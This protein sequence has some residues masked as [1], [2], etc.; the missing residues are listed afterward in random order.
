MKKYILLLTTFAFCFSSCDDWLDV[1]SEN[2]Q[3]EEEQFS[4]YKGFKDAL[5]GCYMKMAEE[6]T[7]GQALT[8]THIETLANLWECPDVLEK[9]SP[10]RYQLNSHNY[11]GNDAQTAIE[12]IYAGLFNIIAQA[13]VIIKHTEEENAAISNTYRSIIAGEAYAI[14]AYCQLDV[15]RLFGQLPQGGSQQ[16]ELP[17]SFC[18][19][20][21]EMPAYYNYAEYVKLLKADIEKALSLLKDN[22]PIF[23][24]TFSALNSSSTL[25]E[26]DFYYYRQSRLNYWAVKA[27]QARMYLYIGETSNAATTAMEIINAK[28]ADEKPLM[29]LS[30][31][32]DMPNKYY[33][34]PSECLFCLSKYNLKESANAYLL[35]GENGITAYET[36]YVL[37]ESRLADLYASVSYST[38]SHNR[39]NNWWNRTVKNNSAIISPALKKYWYTD[40]ATN[41]MLKHQ[42]IPMLR[43]SEIYLIAIETATDLTT[44]NSLYAEYM[45]ACAVTNAPTFTSLEEI[46]EEVINEYRR[47]FF[48]EGQM[49]YTY[50]RNFV[51]KMLWNNNEVTEENYIVPL[52]LTEYNPNK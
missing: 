26:D 38:G 17:Y 20:I 21:D 4:E 14:R 12:G 22:D 37:T 10:G 34:L 9:N 29:P 35:G 51:T 50:K 46:K 15:L 6:S 8:M 11:S 45:R 30:G 49:F 19:G 16:I 39:Y 41:L 43:M 44:A 18:T 31:L 36:S 13:N 2:S 25:L 1:R 52:P 32:S 24:Y 47:E 33:G 40:D 7:Y 3:K 48:G 27:M 5:T 23:D 42:I 28:D